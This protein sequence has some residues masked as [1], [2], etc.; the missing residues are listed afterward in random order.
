M[1][2]CWEKEKIKELTGIGKDRYRLAWHRNY[3]VVGVSKR[4]ILLI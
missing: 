3:G 2:W 1:V 4:R